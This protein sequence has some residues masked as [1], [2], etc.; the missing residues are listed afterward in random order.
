MTRAEVTEETVTEVTELTV[1][2]MTELTDITQ[3]NGGTEV[4][5]LRFRPHVWKSSLS[6]PA[7]ECIANAVSHGA[8]KRHLHSNSP[9]LRFSL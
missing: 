8:R 7:L 6:Y 4:I 3:R 2:E 9:L 1:T 5:L